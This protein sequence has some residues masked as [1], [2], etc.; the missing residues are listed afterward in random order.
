MP[1]HADAAVDLDLDDIARFHPQ[2][3]LAR[4]ADTLRRARR[5]HVAGNERRPVRA[6]GNQGR[7]IKDQIVN[8]GVLYLVAV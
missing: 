4:E 5:N 8:T 2:R 1:R 3:W 6:I 7:D